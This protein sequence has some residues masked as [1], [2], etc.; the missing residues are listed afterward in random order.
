MSLPSEVILRVRFL[1][2]V[3]SHTSTMFDAP[4]STGSWELVAP[5]LTWQV[6]QAHCLLGD[7]F[8][9]LTQLPRCGIKHFLHQSPQRCGIPVS[10]ALGNSI[11]RVFTVCQQLTGLIGLDTLDQP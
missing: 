10:D 5:L 6:P 1:S 7:C 3:N 9:D 8:V 4:I 11:D 2:E